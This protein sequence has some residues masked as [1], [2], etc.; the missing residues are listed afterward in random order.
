VRAGE[1]VAATDVVAQTETA[2]D[3][4]LKD[5]ARELGVPRDKVSAYVVKEEG[6]LVEKGEVIAVR[7]T[8]L[9]QQ[10]I[11]SPV[12]GRLALVAEGRVLLV[13]LS[14]LQLRAGVPGE[15]VN[16][17]PN[18]GVVI[19]LTGALLDGVWGNGQED[20]S[21]L[22]WLADGPNGVLQP[23]QLDLALRGAIVAAARVEEAAVFK[24]LQEIGVRGLILASATAEQIPVLHALTFP[25]LVS[26]GFGTHG[27]CDLAFQLL[28]SGNTREVWLN[29]QPA[30]VRKNVRPTL[31]VPLVGSA[32]QPPAMPLDGELLKEGKRV[33]IVRGADFGRLGTV[34]GLSNR[35]MLL[36]TSARSHV[37][38]I[39]LDEIR[40]S[41]PTVSIPFAN[42][43]LLE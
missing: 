22:R 42:L 10:T 21:V 36:P 9:G 40:G 26:E 41:R 3:H 24:S 33:R 7:K 5:V 31:V 43:E 2:D 1:R 16:I 11:T 34:I 38:A 25:V 39:T 6:D 14:P 30:E 15:V 12:R 28:K 37:A 32:S 19:E 13:A 8:F 4:L 23:A 27:F 29:A 20:T 35:P 17:I 18:Q